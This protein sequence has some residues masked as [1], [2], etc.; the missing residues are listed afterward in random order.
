[1]NRLLSLAIAV[2]VLCA[3]AA[4][5]EETL[6]VPA[7]HETITA[8]LAAAPDGATIVVSEGAYS[9]VFAIERPV[10]LLAEGEVIVRGIDRQRALV[11]IVL[12]DE[13]TIRGF[14][15]E[16]VTPRPTGNPEQQTDALVIVMG[17]A[18][19]FEDCTFRSGA[20][21]GLK[22]GGDTQATFTGCIFEG[23]GQ[24]GAFVSGPDALPQFTDCRFTGNRF[25][26]ITFAAGAR[27]TLTDSE[28]T[29]NEGNGIVIQGRGTAPVVSNTLSQ[30]NAFNGILVL[31]GAAGTLEDNTLLGNG[32]SGI[33]LQVVADAL[34]VRNNRCEDN[35]F[36]GLFLGS[37][38]AATVEDNH[39]E[40]N[41][42]IS[43]GEVSLL[44]RDEN[45]ESLDAIEEHLRVNA[46]RF[47]SGAWQ[48]PF[49]YAYLLGSF[50]G[51][52]HSQTM[53]FEDWCGRWQYAR[54]ES[55]T[56]RIARGKW[57]M[58]QAWAARGGGPTEEVPEAAWAPF[59]EGLAKAYGPLLEAQELVP[60]HPQA[61]ADLVYVLGSV[62][63]IP[64]AGAEAREA[65]WAEVEPTPPSSQA[66]F[67]QGA[68]AVPT[69]VPL[70]TSRARFL[71]PRWGG[72]PGAVEAFAAEQA[73]A[74]A[75]L[76]DDG[77]YAIIANDILFSY[78]LW[79]QVRAYYEEFSFA[80]PRVVQ[81]HRDLIRRTPD[82]TFWAQSL[83]LHAGLQGDRT[84]ATEVFEWMD[85]ANA[86]W[87]SDVW[88]S[89]DRYFTFRAW[90]LE[91]GP[92]PEVS[93]DLLL[94]IQMGNT[95][96]ARTLLEEGAVVNAIGMLGYSPLTYAVD[97]RDASMAALLLEFGADP[98]FQLYKGRGSMHR[99]AAHNDIEII[100]AL[101]QNG[102]DVDFLTDDG[103]TP[104][105]YAAYS[106]RLEAIELLLLNGAV[107]DL[108][109]PSGSTAYIV[110][111][112]QGQLEA[113]KA[114]REA[115]ADPT[116]TT[117]EG[118]SALD[119]ARKEGHDA[120]VAWLEEELPE[121]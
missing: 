66:I 118:E 32:A 110:A 76:M 102:A 47:Q 5:A 82:S 67:E 33:N 12:M 10:T 109:H 104:L 89:E 108:R 44:V 57:H 94:A 49:F 8:A 37:S 107:I 73:D 83:A 27:G 9:E 51:S 46:V 116:V 16:G 13:V 19:Q 22:V 88:Q 42:V 50:P 97:R 31:E 98:D 60:E 113:A 30:D 81:G 93:T 21:T 68:A 79:T 91:D 56:P 24:S 115:G 92:F 43:S 14:V 74:T 62:E 114:L 59:A 100:S 80:W 71:M 70:Y 78:F 41:G 6:R 17:G 55:P 2:S 7:D 35:T 20:H 72:E 119:I 120:I 25:H 69:F 34:V 75:E 4:W 54:P 106:G 45:F 112:R 121:E 48:L 18:P 84:I 26:G 117:V 87:D 99:A 40:R 36:S 52:P 11:S 3:H 39:F 111:V 95:D 38:T 61:F 105:M 1:M 64:D 90:A 63:S 85:E 103:S 58:Q 15:F 101:L 77:L 28:A 23:N 86:R 53:S 96:A 65:A 29:R